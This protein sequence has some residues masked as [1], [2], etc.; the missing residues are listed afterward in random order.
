MNAYVYLPGNLTD[1]KNEVAIEGYDKKLNG[2]VS[3]VYVMDIVKP[4]YMTYALASIFPFTSETIVSKQDMQTYDDDL[5]Y[6]V[7]TFDSDI[8]FSNASLAAFDALKDKLDFTYRE[9][10]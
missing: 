6:A 3:S 4:T 8:S 5:E 2:K 1:V 10:T 9:V 7:G